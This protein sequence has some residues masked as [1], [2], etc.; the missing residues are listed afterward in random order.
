MSQKIN[1][2]YIY[3]YNTNLN[4]LYFFLLIELWLKNVKPALMNTTVKS[5]GSCVSGRKSFL[6]KAVAECL[7]D[8]G[9]RMRSTQLWNFIRSAVRLMRSCERRYQ[10]QQRRRSGGDGC[11]KNPRGLEV[12]LISRLIFGFMCEIWNDIF[13]VWQCQYWYAI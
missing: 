11:P 4:F 2:I 5:G 1:Y 8:F 6:E 10:C 3:F 9:L 12:L 13:N 7:S